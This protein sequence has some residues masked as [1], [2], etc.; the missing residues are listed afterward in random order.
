MKPSKNFVMQAIHGNQLLWQSMFWNTWDSLAFDEKLTWIVFVGQTL[1]ILTLLKF[2][3][4]K[5]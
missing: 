4:L 3:I 1:A 2:F 5:K